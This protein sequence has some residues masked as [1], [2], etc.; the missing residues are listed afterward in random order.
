MTRIHPTALIEDGA[1]IGD[2]V[3]IGP[4]AVIF[5]HAA[6]GPHCRIHTGAVIGDVPQD[7]AFKNVESFVRIGA[8]C[9]IREHVTIHRGTKE[10]TGT[11][12]G[13]GCFLM[14]TAHLAHNVRLGNGVIMANGAQLSGHIV[15]EDQA[16][17]GGMVGVHQFVRIGRLCMVGGYSRVTKDCVPF[18]LVEGSP[19]AVRGLNS[20]GAPWLALALTA[21]LATVM[22]LM[23]Y[24]KSLVEGFTFLTLVVTAANLPLYLCCA[25]ALVSAKLEDRVWHI[26]DITTFMGLRLLGLIPHA[27][28]DLRDAHRRL[29]DLSGSP[30]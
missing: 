4:Y 2:D 27:G 17:I 29:R 12:V 25:L 19:A 28:E 16:V 20:R 3:E 6:I 1:V 14:A 11:E 26:S 8:G 18:M 9:V 13:D 24:S 10:G 30:C 5:R 21:V 23:N 7:L 22:V 15:V